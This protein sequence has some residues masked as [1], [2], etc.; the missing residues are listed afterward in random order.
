[1]N[2]N[3]QGG[4]FSATLRLTSLCPEARMRCALPC[5]YCGQTMVMSTAYVSLKMPG[6][7]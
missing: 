6:P 7:S 5:S 4:R 3:Q 2:A 1:M